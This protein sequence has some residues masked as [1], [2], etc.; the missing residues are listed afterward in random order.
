[1]IAGHSRTGIWNTDDFVC[2]MIKGCIQLG[3]VPEIG[4]MVDI[5][6]VDYVSKAIT[7][8]S[9]QKESEG[10]TFHLANPN[11]ADVGNVV[12]QVRSL[13]YSIEQVSYDQWREKLIND[14]ENALYPLLPVFPERISEEQMS[15]QIQF[16]IRNTLK[17]LANTDIVFPPIDDRLLNTYFSYFI[18]S[19]F[20]NASNKLSKVQ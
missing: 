9:R 16:D 19:G 12:Q 15:G 20:L 7:H 2:R 18:H 6:P 11:P 13:G 14:P 4:A 3:S 8:L 10:K 17:G 1:M 5:L